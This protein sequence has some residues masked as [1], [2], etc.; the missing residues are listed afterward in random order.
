MA[1]TVN[2]V[3]EKCG[4]ASEVAPDKIGKKVRCPHCKTAAIMKEPPAEP[5]TPSEPIVM[6]EDLPLPPPIDGAAD[7]GGTATIEVNIPLEEPT[8]DKTVVEDD[9]TATIDLTVV[10]ETKD[11]AADKTLADEDGTSTMEV[12]ILPDEPDNTAQKTIME[13]TP[14]DATADKTIVDSEPLV[15]PMTAQDTLMDD[16]MTSPA[17]PVSASS[18]E[19]IVDDTSGVTQTVSAEAAPSLK[20]SQQI[21]GKKPPTIITEMKERREL[22]MRWVKSVSA[23][24]GIIAAF[25]FTL[26]LYGAFDSKSSRLKQTFYQFVGELENS[27]STVPMMGYVDVTDRFQKEAGEELFRRWTATTRIHIVSIEITEIKSVAQ[28]G[29]IKYTVSY[30]LEDPKAPP[31]TDASA[32]ATPPPPLTKTMTA[33][34]HY[35]RGRWFFDPLKKDNQKMPE[36]F[37][38][39]KPAEEKKEAEPVAPKEG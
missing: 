14:S 17:V 39:V 34:W 1:K 11:S 3:C 26:Y 20:A 27:R 38:N 10:N 9:L 36:V 5:K 16:T 18:G 8:A 19:T 23:V 4:K 12:T 24:A 7:E 28:Y 13:E 37:L 32:S 35:H 6:E 31:P 29:H 30:T 2:A 22:V 25:F 33:Y 15:T 21:K